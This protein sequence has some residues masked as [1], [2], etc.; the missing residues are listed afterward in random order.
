MIESVFVWR[1]VENSRVSNLYKIRIREGQQFRKRVFVFSRWSGCGGF[2]F[3]KRLVE[4]TDVGW[5]RGK[6]GPFDPSS[7]LLTNSPHDV[8]HREV[9]WL[10]CGT[11]DVDVDISVVPRV[12]DFPSERISELFAK[13]ARLMTETLM[14]GGTQAVPTNLGWSRLAT[15]KTNARSRHW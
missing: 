8:V 6:S 4:G 12:H 2:P 11:A 9:L 3:R 14:A 7:H 1:P 15:A 10:R 5:T 13:A